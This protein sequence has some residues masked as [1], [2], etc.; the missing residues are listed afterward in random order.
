MNLKQK[1]LSQIRISNHA[2]ERAKQRMVICNADPN[3]LLFE[4][5][6]KEIIQKAEFKD[7]EGCDCE[8][9]LI[10]NQ[11]KYKIITTPAADGCVLIKTI[12]GKI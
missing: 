7:F 4:T 3:S 2:L 9:E 6:L 11:Q 10:H 5:K 1:N 8:Y 12:V